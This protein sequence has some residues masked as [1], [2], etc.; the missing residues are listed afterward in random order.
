MF[1]PA[2]SPVRAPVILERT[3]R[4][5]LQ[6]RERRQEEAIV[7]YW[8]P[9]IGDR[10]DRLVVTPDPPRR[11]S[12]NID[13]ACRCDCGALVYV[14]PTALRLGQTRSCGCRLIKHNRHKTPI[15][16]AWKGMHQRCENPATRCYKDYGGR[17]IT[18]CDRWKVFSNFLAD[19]GERPTPQHSLD[20]IDNEGNYS[21]D[22][23]RWA[24]KLEQAQNRRCSIAKRA[25]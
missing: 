5:N 9:N 16:E 1:W 15:Y 21:P 23:C 18:V 3:G 8:R 7:R 20:R 12:K 24:T 6:P 25:A 13:F 11:T 22:N 4:L 10:F 19:M 17:G 14:R 2:L